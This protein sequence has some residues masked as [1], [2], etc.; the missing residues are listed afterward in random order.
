VI[1]T[2]QNLS[3][4]EKISTKITDWVGTPQSILVHTL[5]FIAIF[6]LYF[7]GVTVESILLIL[8]TAVSLEAIYLAIFIQMTVNRNTARLEDVTEDIG[9]IQ[10]DVEDIQEDVGEI[11]GDM[12]VLHVNVKDIGEDVDAIS[13]D[14]DDIEEDV[15]KIHGHVQELGKDVGDIS[16][17][18]D[19]MQEDETTEEA[20]RQNTPAQTM[21]TLDTINQHLELIMNEISELKKKQ[22]Q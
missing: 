8:T 16:D 19:K 5:L 12:D 4:L 10:E 6:G 2:P 20:L 13:R 3:N 14:V 11:G 22:T 18:I 21:V 17:D 7:F 15:D 1:Q 9:E